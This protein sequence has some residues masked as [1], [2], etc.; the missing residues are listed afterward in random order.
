VGGQPLGTTRRN[1]RRPSFSE[2]TIIAR[3]PIDRWTALTILGVGAFMFWGAGH[4]TVFDDEAF[5]CRRYVMPIGEMVSAL[6]HGVEPDPPLYYVLENCWV[7]IFGVAPL[8]LRSLSI[9]FFLGGLI[10]IRMAGQAWFDRTT[11]LVAMVLGGLHPA[12][13]F[14]GF[15]ARWYSLMFLVVAV[16]LWL[17]ARLASAQQGRRGLTAAWGL[18]AAGVCYTNYFGPVIVGLA[19]LVGIMRGRTEPG[20]VRRWMWAALLPLVLYAVWLVPFG[21]QVA[22]FPEVGTSWESYAAT[23]ARTV[24]ALTTGNLASVGAWWAWVPMGICGVGLIALLVRQ[25]RAVWPLGVVTL[26]CLAAGVG[27][28]T[29]IDKYVMT[30]S[31]AACLLAAALLVRGMGMAD[32]EWRNGKGRSGFAL[33]GFAWLSARLAGVCLIIGWTGCAVNLV[34]QRHW[35]SLRWLDPFEQ[36]ISELNASGELRDCVMTHPSARYYYALELMRSVDSLAGSGWR[37]DPHRWRALAEPPSGELDNVEVGAPTPQ[38]ALEK[39]A[40][41]PPSRVVTLE[42]A[43]FAHRAGWIEL[44]RA[45]ESGYA[46]TSE[47]VDY[48]EDRDAAWKD[49]L[50][51]KVHHPRWR[52]VV[53][54]WRLSE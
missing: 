24:L 37:V 45:L 10:F 44:R 27:S 51:P 15:A 28:R 22:A 23:A 19:W 30:F 47:P 20:A 1:R 36:A 11:G 2:T 53:R 34:T 14:F 33:R 29:M 6:W 54:R 17:T 3:T 26:G 13:L 16:L 52:I 8:A 42:T 31:G 25:W 21:R 40:A 46:E 32:G 18:T 4:F 43:G 41:E 39:M 35:S 9:L 50:D 5:S 7:T 48:L 49:R 38:S 12:H